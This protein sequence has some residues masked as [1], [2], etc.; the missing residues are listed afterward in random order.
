MLYCLLINNFQISGLVNTDKWFLLNITSKYN[1]T[2]IDLSESDISI[3]TPCASNFTSVKNITLLGKE[4]TNLVK[5]NGLRIG[6]PSNSKGLS[7]FRGCLGR[8]S[9]DNHILDLFNTSKNVQPFQRKFFGIKNG[10]CR[11][12]TGSCVNGSYLW[13]GKKGKCDCKC[14][15]GYYGEF[16]QNVDDDDDD[17]DSEFI[18]IVVGIA[19]GVVILATLLVCVVLYV[20]RTSSSVFGVYNPKSQE[21]I[22]GEQMNTA[23]TLPVPEKLI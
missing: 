1:S 11:C 15:L 10:S 12:G 21:Q 20:K 18:Y 23:F 14:S 3:K 2:R 22:Q 4:F 13:D 19:V 5:T 16:C 7:S 6:G 17:V 9:L 8:F